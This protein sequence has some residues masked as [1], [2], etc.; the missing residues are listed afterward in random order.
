MFLDTS[1]WIAITSQ[2]EQ[3]HEQA[4]TFYKQLGTGKHGSLVTSDYVLDETLTLLRMRKGVA[5]AIR[6]YEEIFR[7][8]S[9]HVAWV[10]PAIFHQAV[11]TMKR[12]QDKKWSFTDCTSFTIMNQLKIRDAF[13]FDDDYTQAGFTQHP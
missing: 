3:Y 6:F 2:D 10:E 11:D 4:R 1:A 5:H 8:K 12:N 7:S 13:C 9:L